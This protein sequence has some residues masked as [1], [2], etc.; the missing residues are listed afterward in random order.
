MTPTNSSSMQLQTVAPSLV[1][2]L[3]HIN[4]TV[5]VP[6]KELKQYYSAVYTV[7]AEHMRARQ[8]D[9]HSRCDYESEEECN[10]DERPASLCFIVKYVFHPIHR[11]WEQSMQLVS[12]LH[13]HL[14]MVS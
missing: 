12:S 3:P 14:S 2:Q 5:P 13:S 6:A 4:P 10:I 8:R 7:V 9:Y 11:E 1:N